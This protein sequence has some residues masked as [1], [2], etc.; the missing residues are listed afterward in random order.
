[1]QAD[2]SGEH[3]MARCNYLPAGC[4]HGLSLGVLH[5]CLAHVH[6]MSIPLHAATEVDPGS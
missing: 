4:E 3:R 2:A 1:M 5:V 6:V